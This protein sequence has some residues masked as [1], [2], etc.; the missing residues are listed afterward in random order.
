M[1]QLLEHIQQLERNLNTLNGDPHSSV[2][3]KCTDY[4][5]EAMQCQS[6]HPRH[7]YLDHE[8]GGTQRTTAGE[9]Y[10]ARVMP[11][12]KGTLSRLYACSRD[13]PTF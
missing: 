12:V 11:T 1:L 3:C 9:N 8:H 7:E 4:Y 6:L 2:V 5:N 13:P 10:H